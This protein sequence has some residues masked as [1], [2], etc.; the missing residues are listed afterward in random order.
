MAV[1]EVLPSIK[2][3]LLS[4][5]KTNLKSTWIDYGEIVL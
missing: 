5:R 4:T 3:I 2:V 1:K